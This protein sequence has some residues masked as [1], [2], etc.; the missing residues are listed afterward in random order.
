MCVLAQDSRQ[1]FLNGAGGPKLRN[2]FLRLW[3]C[4]WSAFH[5]DAL[6]ALLGDF[7]PPSR[8]PKNLLP[9][10]CATSM[11]LSVPIRNEAISPM[12]LAIIPLAFQAYLVE[13][14]L[15]SPIPRVEASRGCPLGDLG[16]RNLW[17]PMTQDSVWQLKIAISESGVLIQYVY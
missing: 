4:D 6:E 12:I 11:K 2:G 8:G 7:R 1:Q 15:R 16:F 17:P 3:A 9:G 14:F 10:L 5:G 13:G